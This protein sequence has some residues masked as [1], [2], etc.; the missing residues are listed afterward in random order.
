MVKIEELQVKMNFSVVQIDDIL[1]TLKA[2]FPDFSHTL[3]GYNQWSKAILQQ[4]RM[5][6]IGADIELSTTALSF[7]IESVA[8][9]TSRIALA[10][11]I[12]G[13]IV[14]IGFGIVDVVQSVQQ[15]KRA[16]DELQKATRRLE[17]AKS[18]IIS[19][20]HTMEDTQKKLCSTII[21]YFYNLG[22]KGAAYH[23][24]FGNLKNFLTRTYFSH[25]HNCNSKSVYGKS[26]WG[27]LH[28]LVDSALRPINSYTYH[29]L[30]DLRR[31]INEVTSTKSYLNSITLRLKY[32]RDSPSEIFKT[33]HTRR[34]P[35]AHDLFSTLFSVLKYAAEKV[36]PHTACFWGYNLNDIRSKHLTERNFN[37][38]KVCPSPEISS[39]VNLIKAGERNGW[40]PCRI[41]R[42]TQGEL[43]D[44]NT[45]ILQFIANH[46]STKSTCYW[47]F[48]LRTFRTGS[49]P[50]SA[51]TANVTS[52]IF[53]FLKVANKESTARTIMC[54]ENRICD[55]TW[56]KF[57]LC[58][59]WHGTSK[60][61]SLHCNGIGTHVDT[62]CI[63]L[64]GSVENCVGS[65]PSTLHSHS[66]SHFP[67][68][69]HHDPDYAK[70]GCHLCPNEDLLHNDI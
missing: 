62:H 12:I 8:S 34:P 18:N 33:A 25:S 69:F 23:R 10:A 54:K 66:S 47:G 5:S 67:N 53:T 57:V 44:S 65:K 4:A 28:A 9:V 55:P 21:T 32:K 31:R 11:S 14:A 58:N 35:Y 40:A 24:V 59:A 52:S 1:G 22:N 13:G 19:A 56:Q 63:P 61:R 20:T 38:Y 50:S 6:L 39:T 29:S 7:A 43:F 26:T 37:Q 51:A 17:S 27:N 48:D 36:H 60:V 41:L 49:S 45:R 3:D 15:E 2:D 64:A 42:Q 70:Y 16:R 68:F 46:V 30:N